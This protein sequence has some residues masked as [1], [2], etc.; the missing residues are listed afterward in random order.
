MT[1]SLYIHGTTPDE[2]QR[3][4][5]LNKLLND[6]ALQRLALSG[7]EKIL[8]V[9]SGLGQFTRAMARAAGAAGR[10]VGIER[11]LEQLRESKRLAGLEGE[12][13]LVDLRQGNATALPLRREEWASFDIVHTRFVLEH[14]TDPL[15]VVRMM[16]EAVRPGG[17]IILQDDDHDVLRIFPEPLGFYELWQAYIRSYEKLGNDPY[18]GRRLVSLLHQSG[19]LPTKNEWL[20]FGSCAGHPHFPAYASNLRGVIESAKDAIVP[21]GLLD[22]AKFDSAMRALQEWEQKADASLWYAVCWAEATKRN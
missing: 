19:A 9:G 11:S 17:R 2:Q 13:D 8:D 1:E 10:V 14:V 6:S 7:G 5:L 20:F 21:V 4:S 22:Q 18:V 3:L 12:E 15:A 16:V